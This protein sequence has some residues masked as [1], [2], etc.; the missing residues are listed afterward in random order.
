MS[1]SI[2]SEEQRGEKS[3]KSS[4]VPGDKSM[5]S[6]IEK[7]SQG[8]ETSAQQQGVSSETQGVVKDTQAVL[9]DTKE[10]F[11]ERVQEE[12]LQS[13][14]YH[15]TKLTEDPRFHFPNF[16][17]SQATKQSVQG[18]QAALTFV[19]QLVLSSEFRKISMNLLDIMQEI[20]QLSTTEDEPSSHSSS[21]YYEEEGI[22][23][24]PPGTE[25][26]LPESRRFS[27]PAMPFRGHSHVSKKKEQESTESKSGATTKEKGSLQ[28]SD[29]QVDTIVDR[30]VRILRQVARNPNFRIAFH[31]LVNVLSHVNEWTKEIGK[32][33]KE[34]ILSDPHSQQ[35]LKDARDIIEEFAG[36]ESV[37][38]LL[39]KVKQL[40]DKLSQ[41][42]EV[43]D[44]LD[45]L[46]D[47]TVETLHDPQRL[48]HGSQINKI[49]NFIHRGRKIVI[50][51]NYSEVNRQL[52]NKSRKVI[53]N[54]REDPLSQRFV[55]DVCRLAKDITTTREGEKGVD[56]KVI[57]ELRDV[58]IPVIIREL[59][60]MPV[61]R[62]ESH[63]DKYDY[64]ADDIYVSARDLVPDNIKL[65][66]D[67]TFSPM[68]SESKQEEQQTNYTDLSFKAKNIT[69]QMNDV[70]FWFCRKQFPKREDHGRAD[71]K[72]GERGILLKIK[73]RVHDPSTKP[74]F[75]VRRCKCK[76]DALRVKVRDTKSNWLYN[77]FLKLFSGQLRSQIEDRIEQR[78]ENIVE[79]INANVEQQM[80]NEQSNIQ[81]SSK[82]KESRTEKPPLYGHKLKMM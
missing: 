23:Y 48:E 40:G 56:P 73:L 22:P 2:P 64:W 11:S 31:S 59:D 12:R 34:T 8:I 26:H 44:F 15:G 46:K 80:K 82:S 38:S 41:D 6:T 67:T 36:H 47:W 16:S 4:N 18:V 35:A 37:E 17:D 69:A 45:D 43:K 9:E 32:E 42:K 78:I 5:E 10:I 3:M 7:V 21:K 60:Y 68:P 14:I 74:V 57:S 62:V 27:M 53:N 61:P 79:L 1:H 77:L 29:E 49:K 81:Y 52:F 66:L 19:T 50:E 71:V 28:L 24:H 76:L 75:Q 72:I 13:L 25:R 58:L 65:K 51:Y 70:Q 20:F 30:S 33:Q 55:N 54:I 63:G 39:E